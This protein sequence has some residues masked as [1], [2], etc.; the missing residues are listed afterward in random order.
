MILG[1][2]FWNSCSCFS[3]SNKKLVFEA[4]NYSIQSISPSESIPPILCLDLIR[5]ALLYMNVFRFYLT[6]VL[7]IFIFN[8]MSWLQWVSVELTCCAK[9]NWITILWYIFID[10]LSV[11]FILWLNGTLLVVPDEEFGWFAMSVVSSSV[12]KAKVN[13]NNML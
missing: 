13:Y 1:W 12:I 5:Y 7:I 11:G 2:Q 8:A 6:A 9:G 10:L 3:I 4:Y